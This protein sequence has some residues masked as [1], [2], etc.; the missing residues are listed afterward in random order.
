MAKQKTRCTIGSGSVHTTQ[1]AAARA[2]FASCELRRKAM[3]E[4]ANKLWFTSAI[5]TDP[6]DL[7]PPPTMLILTDWQCVE[8]QLQPFSD[9]SCTQELSR[10]MKRASCALIFYHQDAEQV[11]IHSGTIPAYLSSPAKQAN[12]QAWRWQWRLRH[13]P[14]R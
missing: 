8:S 9:G 6:S 11:A 3:T 5:A 10:E 12:L 14:P 2:R 7:L 1:V 4:G 13:D